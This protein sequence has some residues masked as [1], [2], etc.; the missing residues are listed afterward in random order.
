LL[1]YFASVWHIFGPVPDRI[2]VC[3]NADAGVSFLNA[4]AQLCK[5][6]TVLVLT[7]KE[8][9]LS[10]LAVLYTVPKAVGKIFKQRNF[11]SQHGGNV[12]SL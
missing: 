3:R 1:E 6:A 11:P 4:D 5:K 7:S 10:S 2:G 9:R 12:G 8:Q